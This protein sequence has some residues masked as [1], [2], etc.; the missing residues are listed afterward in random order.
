[1]SR[2]TNVE[3]AALQAAADELLAGETAEAI[4]LDPESDRGRS[5]TEALQRGRD[6][7]AERSH[8]LDYRP[9]WHGGD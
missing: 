5:F 7:L 8:R 3:A 9:P 6:V 1:M 4:G 2:L